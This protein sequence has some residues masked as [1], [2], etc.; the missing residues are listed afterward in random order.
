MLKLSS[1]AVGAAVF[2]TVSGLL[3]GLCLGLRAWWPAGIFLAAAFACVMWSG[4]VALFID[5]VL[6]KHGIPLE[7][8]Y[9]T[10]AILKKVAK[11]TVVRPSSPAQ[12]IPGPGVKPPR[13]WPRPAK[14]KVH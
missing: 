3:A 4:R 2:G 12:K 14:D 13:P 9:D 8:I 10:E 5:S 11:A 1:R 7:G 6:K